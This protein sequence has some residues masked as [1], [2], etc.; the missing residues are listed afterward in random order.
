LLNSIATNGNLIPFGNI[1]LCIFIEH[2][3]LMTEKC[4]ISS[5]CTFRQI[6]TYSY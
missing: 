2:S 5:N 1:T 6:G 4:K 3:E